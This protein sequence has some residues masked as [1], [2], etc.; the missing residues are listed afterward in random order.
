MP[1]VILLIGRLCSGKSTYAAG[2]AKEGVIVLSCDDVMQTLFPEPL[3]DRYDRYAARAFRYLYAQARRLHAQGYPVALDFGFWT[4]KSREEAQSE[5]RGIP[6]D[7]R[8]ID[9]D[10]EEWRRRI[11]RRNAA[12]EQ[13]L[14]ERCDYLVDD[15]LLSKAM[16]LY[17]P[18]TADEGLSIR[19]V[20]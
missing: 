12:I 11:A 16:A 20:K 9:I 3:G 15:G 5:L 10:D 8:M 19:L 17:E 13:R 18:P 7:W 4:R 2:L 1:S 6:L 14:S